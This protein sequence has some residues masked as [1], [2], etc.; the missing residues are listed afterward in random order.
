MKVYIKTN[1]IGFTIPVP[2]AL[3]KFGISIMK[4]PFIQKYIAEKDKKYINIIDFEK[5]SDCVDILREYKGLKIV[6][7]QSKDRT[8]VA[9]TL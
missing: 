2:N 9:I 7:V 6:D 5:L 8:H 1:K 3:L 4:A